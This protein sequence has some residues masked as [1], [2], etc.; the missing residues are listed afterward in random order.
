MDA[1]RHTMTSLFSQLGL[2]ENTRAIEEFVDGHGPLANEVALCH[3]PFWND[4]QRS[5]LTEEMV[6]DA[7]W[8]GVID[9]LNRLLHRPARQTTRR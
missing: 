1:N 4:A 7:D 3:A 2:S 9:E 6:K 5:F 8:V